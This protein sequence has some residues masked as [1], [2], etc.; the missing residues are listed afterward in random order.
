MSIELLTFTGVDRGTRLRDLTGIAREYSKVEF[1]VLIGSQAGGIFCTLE[2]AEE[3][4]S[5]CRFQGIP[6]ALHLCGQYARMVMDASG[7]VRSRVYNLL[8][9][10]NGFNRVQINLHGDYW[11]PNRIDV[12]TENARWFVNAVT[13]NDNVDSVII[14]H[15][16]PWQDVPLRHPKVEYLFDLS[17][18]R[19]AEDFDAWPEP[20]AGLGRVGYA[21]GL[22]P[23]N[24]DR[25]VAFSR[26][27]S[28]ARLWFDMES[29]V[30]AAG[31]FSL[32]KVAMVCARVWASARTVEK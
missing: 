23:H 1:G 30:R 29:N 24:I 28:E 22:G 26:K 20:D 2:E 15:R 16:G 32:S 9:V 10:C 13:H 8:G 5:F 7:P 17:E 4:K 25:A 6:S 19:G 27:H 31:A 21:G 3:F 14:Q 11:D 12:T 18:G